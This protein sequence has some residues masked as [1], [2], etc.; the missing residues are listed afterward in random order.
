MNYLQ[1]LTSPKYKY[2]IIKWLENIGFKYVEFNDAMI[3]TEIV[4]DNPF[5]RKERLLVIKHNIPHHISFAHIVRDNIREEFIKYLNGIIRKD[6]ID[7]LL[8]SYI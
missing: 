2:D 7:G 4:A 1:V 3:Y 5:P 8:Q 6:K